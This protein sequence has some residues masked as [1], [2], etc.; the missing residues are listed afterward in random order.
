M[1]G[2]RGRGRCRGSA[3]RG[4][5]RCTT[6]SSL[7]HMARGSSTLREGSA[8]TT[9]ISSTRHDG[10][11]PAL[12]V[13]GLATSSPVSVTVTHPR[14]HGGQS[15]R[16]PARTR[17][18]PETPRQRQ[19]PGRHPL[20]QQVDR[21][22][23]HPSGTHSCTARSATRTRR[24]TRWGSGHLVLVL[25]T[26]IRIHLG[27]LARA[28]ERLDHPAHLG[29]DQA[30]SQRCARRLVR[31]AVHVGPARRRQARARCRATSY[32][33]ILELEKSCS[34]GQV[35]KAYRKVRGAPL[36]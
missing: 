19:L 14:T 9:R 32:Y 7:A 29:L 17:H 8:P 25:I 35:K 26:T 24:R 23:R 20:C 15:R 10:V 30:H 2:H 22:G 31:Q 27:H 11:R 4:M 1:R 12:A 3:V 36:P 13:D 28:L 34:D 16:G 6:C 5:R 33:E 21:L 18:R